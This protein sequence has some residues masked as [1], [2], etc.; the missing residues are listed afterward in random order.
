MES[1]LVVWTPLKNMKV[2]GKDD[3]PY[4]KWKI[5]VMFETNKQKV[6]AVFSVTEKEKNMV[7]ESL[8][9]VKKFFSPTKTANHNTTNNNDLF[10]LLCFLSL[11]RFTLLYYTILY[12]T[13]P[14]YTILNIFHH[15]TEQIWIGVSWNFT[16]NKWKDM[17]IWN[18]FMQ[19]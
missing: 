19:I 1:W 17:D 12:Y 13:I 14:Y 4:M 7:S 6:S 5:K 11:H 8:Q 15:Q 10:I 9:L 18:K 3:I 16:I 2:N